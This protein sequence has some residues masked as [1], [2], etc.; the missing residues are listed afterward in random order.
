MAAKKGIKMKGRHVRRGDEVLVFCIFDLV[1]NL[2]LLKE[3][4]KHI[5]QN[6]RYASAATKFHQPGQMQIPPH[7]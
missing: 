6:K 4:S 7:L 5:R 1:V 3:T 2:H